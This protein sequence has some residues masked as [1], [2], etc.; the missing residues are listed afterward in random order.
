MTA[1]RPHGCDGTDCWRD[2]RGWTHAVGCTMRLMQDAGTH[3]YEAF[4]D[5]LQAYL[6]ARGYYQP[7]RL[8]F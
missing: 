1:V 2:E 3:G 5:C 4:D 7:P 8:S 6:K